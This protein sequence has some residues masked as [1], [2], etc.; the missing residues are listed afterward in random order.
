MDGVVKGIVEIDMGMVMVVA[1]LATLVVD[2][3][4]ACEWRRCNES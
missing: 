4:D 2:L 3:K 1:E